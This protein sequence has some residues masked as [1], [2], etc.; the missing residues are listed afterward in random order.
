MQGLVSST[1][2]FLTKITF[3]FSCGYTQ[4]GIPDKCHRMMDKCHPAMR[5]LKRIFFGKLK[6]FTSRWVVRT[7][8]HGN[9]S[10]KPYLTLDLSDVV[11]PSASV[12]G[13]AVHPWPGPAIL[14]TGFP[15]WTGHPAPGCM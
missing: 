11:G 4:K 14:G 13:P 9:D 12:H 7:E 5:A 3:F 8:T 6:T 1:Y 10:F 2:S 15:G